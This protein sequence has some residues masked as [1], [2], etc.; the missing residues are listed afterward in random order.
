MQK[1]TLTASE[2]YLPESDVLDVERMSSSE[3]IQTVDVML[4]RHFE[5][6]PGQLNNLVSHVRL[7]N[8]HKMLHF[9]PETATKVKV[10]C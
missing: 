3:V 5:L 8:A 10:R 1:I 9:L 2:K 4:Q 7:H 6:T